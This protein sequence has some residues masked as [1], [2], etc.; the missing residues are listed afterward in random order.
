MVK[1]IRRCGLSY[2]QKIY[3][4]NWIRDFSPV[5]SGE[6]ISVEKMRLKS[7]LLGIFNF[8]KVMEVG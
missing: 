2:R 4:L 1:T 8:V 3:I 6:F 5:R 7:L